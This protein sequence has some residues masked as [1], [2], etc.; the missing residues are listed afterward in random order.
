MSNQQRLSIP[1][2]ASRTLRWSHEVTGDDANPLVISANFEGHG[3]HERQ[4]IV[5]EIEELGD[6]AWSNIS[7]DGQVIFFELGFTR[8]VGDATIEI[9]F[10]EFTSPVIIEGD[11]NEGYGTSDGLWHFRHHM[12]T[13]SGVTY[14]AILGFIGEFS[15][16]Q[17]FPDIELTITTR[18]G[19]YRDA[20]SEL[21][22]GGGSLVSDPAA[23]VWRW[24]HEQR[25][26]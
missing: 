2:G 7:T 14:N 15:P 9:E 22:E 5:A 19:I 16:F 26:A 23:T 12:P 8:D 6:W 25:A 4:E 18:S 1:E 20:F 17:R 11:F 13:G 10:S 3:I 24:Q 21:A